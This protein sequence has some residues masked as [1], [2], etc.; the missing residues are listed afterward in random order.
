MGVA[1]KKRDWS[2]RN[3]KAVQSRISL[4]SGKF[5]R[6]GTSGFREFGDWS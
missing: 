4:L 2:H 3:N 1:V 6:A 5:E